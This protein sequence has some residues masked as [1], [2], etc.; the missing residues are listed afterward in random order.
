[1]AANSDF[2]VLAGIL[3]TVGALGVYEGSELHPVFYSQSSILFGGLVYFAYKTFY[4][5]RK[6]ELTQPVDLDNSQS[7]DKSKKPEG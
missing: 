4:L 5:N 1:M 6:T 3:T 7:S 2:W